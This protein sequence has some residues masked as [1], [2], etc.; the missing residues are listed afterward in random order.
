MKTSIPAYLFILSV[1]CVG[2]SIAAPILPEHSTSIVSRDLLDPAVT[3]FQTRNVDNE[4]QAGVAT[5]IVTHEGAETSSSQSSQGGSSSSSSQ[6]R[7]GRQRQ[8]TIPKVSPTDAYK[9]NRRQALRAKFEKIMPDIA[10]SDREYNSWTPYKPGGGVTYIY[11]KKTGEVIEERIGVANTLGT[12]EKGK[13]KEGVTRELGEPGSSTHA[14]TGVD[15]AS[16]EHKSHG[17]R[18]SEA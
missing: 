14:Q 3:A 18:K 8:I 16:K 15:V 1:L 12:G 7:F 4:P 6:P 5:D 13:G 17:D 2:T 9:A 10:V 11:S